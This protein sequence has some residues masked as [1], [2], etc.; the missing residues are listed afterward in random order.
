MTIPRIEI[1]RLKP[2]NSGGSLRAFADIALGPLTIREARFIKQDGKAGFCTGPQSEWQDRDGGKR[3]TTLVAWP[4]EWGEAITR[5]VEEALHDHPN[6]IQPLPPPR[7]APKT[8]FGREVHQRAGF[9]GGQR[10]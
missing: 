7:N 3:Y 2:V 9:Q 10:R 5:A 4:P 8:E 6:G 1:H